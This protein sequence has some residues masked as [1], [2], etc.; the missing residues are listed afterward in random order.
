MPLYL[1]ILEPNLIDVVQTHQNL[2]NDLMQRI[3]PALLIKVQLLLQLEKELFIN[4]HKIQAVKD[5]LECCKHVSEKVV[6]AD[7]AFY[8]DIRFIQF[9]QLEFLDAFKLFVN[10]DQVSFHQKATDLLIVVILIIE[11]IHVGSDKVLEDPAVDAVGEQVEQ[12]EVGVHGPALLEVNIV[13][14][15]DQ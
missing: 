3:L 9:K 7:C 6:K 14:I 8:R 11:S 1:V 5:L 2:A 13:V 12:I 4:K 15:F 10:V